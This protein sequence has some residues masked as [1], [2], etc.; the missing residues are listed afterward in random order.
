MAGMTTAAETLPRLTLD[1]SGMHCAGCAGAVERALEKVAG[2]GRAKVNLPLSRADVEAPASSAADLVEAVEAAGYGAVPRLGS[3]LE[4]RQAAD[5]AEVERRSEERMTLLRLIAA[6]LLTLP[7]LVDMIQSAVRGTGPLLDPWLQLALATPVQFVCG[8][9]FLKGA[10][11]ALERGRANMDVLVALG[12]LSAWGFSTW[13][14]LDGEAGHGHALYF[15]GAAAVITFV[16]LGKVL[17]ARARKGAVSVLNALANERPTMARVWRDGAWRETPADMIAPGERVLLRAGE[18]APAD[19]TV[20]DGMSDMDEALVTGESVP[21]A[22]APGARV[23]AGALNGNGTLTIEA[24]AVGED[25][26][27]ARITRLV[28]AAQ[29]GKAPLQRLADRISAVFVP[30]VLVLAA[31]T[32]AGW[33][34]F[35][36]TETAFVAA[37]SVLVVACPCALGLATPVALV[38]GTG[39]AAKAGI[40]VRD[41]AALEAAA[42]VDTVAFDKTGTITEG[43]PKLT[44]VAAP[45]VGSEDAL[46]LAA[47][48]AVGSDHPL[49]RAIV[50]AAEDRGIVPSTASDLETAPGLGVR[51][52]INGVEAL[53]GNAAHLREHSIA[54]GLIEQIIH[55]DQSFAEA[56]SVVWLAGAGKVIGAFAFT[57][58][59]RRHAPDVVSALAR[60]GLDTVLLSGDR[61]KAAQAVARSAGIADARGELTPEKKVAA[62][63]ALRSKAHRVAMVGDGI[64]DAPALAMADVG[65]AMAGG[66]DAARSSAGLI[67]MRPDLRL[68]PEALAIARATR[69]TIR[70][71]LLLAFVFNIGGIGAAMAGLLTPAIAG[72]AM[73]ASSVSVVLNA[74]RL[75]R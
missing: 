36:Q 27:L 43:V 11:M 5:R 48:L 51:G 60:A 58:T 3:A 68:V 24:A 7:F 4:R 14:I 35:G 44:A 49:S 46:R 47:A 12:T 55:Q 16:L 9:P 66:T 22:K 32:A 53:L 63:R 72:A 30:L 19:G 42:G 18:R 2:S 73:A 56:Q 41:I 38:A 13:L 17:E 65:I 74:L 15:E 67:L 28:E 40:I 31:G 45:G 62:L 39:R 71:N 75:S 1:I 69:L 57:D 29:I 23:I 6:T 20:L 37:I 26:T 61:E 25:T 34:W 54:L 70:Q 50:A 21:V 64:N 59:L 33:W 52:R 8:Y 10:G